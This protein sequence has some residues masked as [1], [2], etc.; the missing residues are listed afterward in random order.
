MADK[1]R[2][3]FKH[4]II[5]EEAPHHI[6]SGERRVLF[7]GQFFMEI[8]FRETREFGES[9]II[10]DQHPSQISLPA[11]GNTYC[12]QNEK[13]PHFFLDKHRQDILTY[14]KKNL[15]CMSA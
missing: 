5:I 3:T 12:M 10:L 13:Y 8:T 14:S 4:A 1:R 7:G 6:L 11:L 15:R 2:E 9:L